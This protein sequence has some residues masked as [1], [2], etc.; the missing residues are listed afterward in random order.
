VVRGEGGFKK[1]GRREGGREGGR[2]GRSTCKTK[3][4][5]RETICVKDLTIP[6]MY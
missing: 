4:R 6:R 2:E 1:A 5:S 3:A